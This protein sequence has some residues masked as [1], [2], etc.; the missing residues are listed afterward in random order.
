MQS[1]HITDKHIKCLLIIW[2]QCIP[3]QAQDRIVM[4]HC[5]TH[6]LP[7][8]WPELCPLV[9]VKCL[10]IPVPVISSAMLIES[11][12]MALPSSIVPT[13]TSLLLEFILHAP[14]AFLQKSLLYQVYGRANI[15]KKKY[16]AIDLN[17]LIC[18][19]WAWNQPLFPLD[20]H[21]SCA[22]SGN[23]VPRLDRTDSDDEVYLPSTQRD[24]TF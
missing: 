10:G 4:W 6:S 1:S 11:W 7:G 17:F 9:S 24:P 8:D 18:H 23:I 21:S 19:V 5:V 22:S 15:K 16:L 12:V 14:Y 3:V 20:S 13:L 2:L